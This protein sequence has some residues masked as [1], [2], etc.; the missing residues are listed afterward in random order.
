M[1]NKNNDV[2]E[3]MLN[4][5]Y[6]SIKKT[7]ISAKRFIFTIF[8][9]NL[10]VKLSYIELISIIEQSEWKNEFKIYFRDC[11]NIGRYRFGVGSGRSDEFL[12]YLLDLVASDFH[13]FWS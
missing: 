13:Y 10:I 7:K 3:I 9:E 12:E 6:S 8:A 5:N 4:I 2:F 11:I 1:I